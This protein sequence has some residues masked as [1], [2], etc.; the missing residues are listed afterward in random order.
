[1]ITPH[2]LISAVR[3]AIALLVSAVIIAGCG[4]NVPDITGRWV[5]ADSLDTIWPLLY[6]FRADGT[7][8]QVRRDCS[9]VGLIICRETFL[10]ID[11]VAGVWELK[12]SDGH[13]HLCIATNEPIRC[14]PITVIN[15]RSIQELQF[16][17]PTDMPSDVLNDIGRVMKSYR[18]AFND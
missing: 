11:T 17:P 7:M 12:R 8:H 1:M 4:A 16:G 15:V 6:E 2:R 5:N 18:R 14:Y 10:A 9:N 13:D 3:S